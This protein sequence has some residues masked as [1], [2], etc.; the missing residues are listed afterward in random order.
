MFSWKKIALGCSALVLASVILFV[1][2][3][4]FLTLDPKDSCLDYGGRYD[5]QTQTCEK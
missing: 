1:A 4:F 2:G 5:E 3:M